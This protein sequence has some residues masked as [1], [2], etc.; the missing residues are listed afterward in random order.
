MKLTPCVYSHLPFTSP[1]DAL[2]HQQNYYSIWHHVCQH[3]LAILVPRDRIE[4]PIPDYKTGVIPLTEQGLLLLILVEDGRIELPIEACK[5]TVFP[6]I[7][8]PRIMTVLMLCQ[9]DFL[10]IRPDQLA[11]FLS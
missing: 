1:V 10:H 4:L 9:L 6:A 8:I 3:V 11:A 7:P 2:L 5:A